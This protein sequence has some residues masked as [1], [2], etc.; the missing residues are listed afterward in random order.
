MI[1]AAVIGSSPAVG[2]SRST[3]SG[4]R[5]RARARPTRFFMPPEISAGSFSRSLSIPT[6]ESSSRA[7]ALRSLSGS[8][9]WRLSGK[10]TFSS[11]VSESYRAACWNKKPSFLRISLS[12]SSGSAAISCPPISMD[13]AS[14]CCRP[15]INFSKTLFPVPLRP[16]IVSIS[17]RR[18]SRSIPSRTTCAPKDLRSAPTRMTGPSVLISLVAR[19]SLVIAYLKTTMISLTKSTSARMT[20]SEA[21]TTELVAERPTPSVPPAVRIP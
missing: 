8:A 1:S 17:P 9:V 5:A 20:K 7:R 16:R 21:I 11:T 13:P 12:R 10:A 18:T 14:G 6:C 2:S 4:S 15:M 19:P 3:T